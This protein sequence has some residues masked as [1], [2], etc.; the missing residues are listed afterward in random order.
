[1]SDI[2]KRMNELGAKMQKG[3]AKERDIM[4]FHLLFCKQTIAEL[5]VGGT[6]ELAVLPKSTLIVALDSMAM[7]MWQDA[8]KWNPQEIEEQPEAIDG[9]LVQEEEGSKE[10]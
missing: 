1:M 3:T 4:D 7:C 8:W 9:A 5:N 6:D 2:L 10:A